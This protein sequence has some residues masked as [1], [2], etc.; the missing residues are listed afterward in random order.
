MSEQNFM[1]VLAG[2][3]PMARDTDI[4]DDGYFIPVGEKH[5]SLA[6][7]EFEPGTNNYGAYVKATLG[8]AICDPGEDQDREFSTVYFINASKDGKLSF[9]GQ[10]MVRIATLLAGEPIAENNP[11]NAAAVIE[12]SIGAV[13]RAKCSARKDKKSGNDYP[14]VRPI[15]LEATPA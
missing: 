5:L 2:F 1:D 8:W 15:S 6:S 10:D 13:I 9:G 11:M 7:A 3:V 14:R 12:G 4:G